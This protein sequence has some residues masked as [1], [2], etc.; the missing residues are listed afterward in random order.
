MIST[1]LDDRSERAGERYV[2]FLLSLRGVLGASLSTRPDDH[3]VFEQIR[4]G[5][6]EVASTFIDSEEDRFASDL[7]DAQER[8]R[9]LV[10]E[11]AVGG[12]LK[13]VTDLL[14]F[15]D[16]LATWFRQELRAQIERDVNVLVQKRR[17]L[18]LQ[19]S[20]NAKSSRVD[21]MTAYLDLIRMGRQKVDFFFTDRAGRRYPSQRFARQLFR[22]GL[23]T[24]ALE[25]YA[26]EGVALGVE[27]VEVETSDPKNSFSGRILALAEHADFQTLSEVR[28]EIFHPN[29]NSFIR[30]YS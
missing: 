8:A 2:A 24:F 10:Q 29:S 20:M 25:S 11:H 23:L 13:S 7:E 5:A 21:L 3:R 9:T 27:L 30:A 28:D 14:D 6:Y 19:A 15:S 4:S 22:Q 1:F 26:I 17:E 12:P 18:V 16:E